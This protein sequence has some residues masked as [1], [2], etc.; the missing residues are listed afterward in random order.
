V[1]DGAGD[2][3][4]E[5]VTLEP[6][7]I[8]QAR[9]KLLL[10]AVVPPQQQLWFATLGVVDALARVPAFRLSWLPSEANAQRVIAALAP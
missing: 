4:G 8:A 6:L 9:R 3:R 2:A 10:V 7:T 1:L 5:D